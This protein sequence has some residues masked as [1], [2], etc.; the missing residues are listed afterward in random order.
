[1]ISNMINHMYRR[2]SRVFHDRNAAVHVS[3]HASRDELALMLNLIRPRYFVPVHGEYRHLC[4][5]AELAREVGLSPDAVFL[6]EDGQVLEVDGVGARRTD[7]V[8]AGRVFVDGKGI[9]DVDDIVLR[10]RRHLSRDGF[11][12]VVLALD[13]NSGDL[14]AGPEFLSRG[15]F[16]EGEA[17]RYYEDAREVVLA[18]LREIAAESRTDPLEVTEEV[19][20][21]LRRYLHKTLARSPVV[22]P[23]VMEM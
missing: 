3:G 7:G 6:L 21:S 8:A 14:V 20:K 15:V 9:G 4:H 2:G 10:D 22:L 1:M 5:H 23:F 16:D 19:R 18:I 17:N 13:R 11:L 12:I